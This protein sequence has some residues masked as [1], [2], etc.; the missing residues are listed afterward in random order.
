MPIKAILETLYSRRD[1]AGN[2]YYSF[3]YTDVASGKQV[4]GTVSG[5]QSNVDSIIREMG[6]TSEEVYSTTKE[7][8]IR[9]FNYIT[10]EWAYGGCRADELVAFIRAKLAQKD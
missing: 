3:K 9:D 8:A 5:G 1:R 6:Y 7:L 4:Y 10:R 2:C